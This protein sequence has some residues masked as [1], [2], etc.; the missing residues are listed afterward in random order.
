MGCS[1]V[2]YSTGSSHRWCRFSFLP[3]QGI[4]FPEST[5]C[6][7]SLLVSLHPPFTVA[8][9]SICVHDKDSVVHVRVRWIM[10]TQKYPA[11]TISDKNN[12]LDDCGRS[13]ERRRKKDSTD[14]SS[15]NKVKTILEQ[16]GH[17][18]QFQDTTDVLPR[19][20]HLPV[21]LWI[22]DPHSRAA[23]KNISRGNEVLPQDTTH[24]IQR[25][26]CQRESPC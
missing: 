20:V 10:A 22:M 23:K 25:P 13:M 19:H 24:L 3:W 15:I 17:F 21:C 9:I 6:A 5:F 26:C 7:D 1:S 12:Q 4:F 8:C 18:S 2:G 16:Q 11:C 14:S